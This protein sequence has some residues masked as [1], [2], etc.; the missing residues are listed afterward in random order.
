MKAKK[1]KAQQRWSFCPKNPSGIAIQRVTPLK[2]CKS[3]LCLLDQPVKWKKSQSVRVFM[4]RSWRQ[5]LLL[6]DPLN[7]QCQAK[8]MQ[9]LN[10]SDN[11]LFVSQQHVPF[12]PVV[13]TMKGSKKCKMNWRLQ[14]SLAISAVEELL[15]LGQA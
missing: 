2:K 10:R 1:R 5:V 6:P 13:M 4:Q 15:I 7:N 8:K 12:H 9:H 3:P 11:K 14:L